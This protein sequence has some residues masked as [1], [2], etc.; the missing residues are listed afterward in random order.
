MKKT[1]HRL[2]LDMKLSERQNQSGNVANEII[3]LSYIETQLFKVKIHGR[4]F[5]PSKFGTE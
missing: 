5:R 2:P 1:S 4:I 3:R